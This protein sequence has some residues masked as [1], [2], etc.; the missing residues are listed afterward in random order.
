MRC[1]SHE[2]GIGS[3]SIKPGLL[4]EKQARVGGIDEFD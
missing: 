4:S 3:I 2:K 1:Q